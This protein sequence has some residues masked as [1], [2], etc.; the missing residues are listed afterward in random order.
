MNELASKEDLKGEQKQEPVARKGKPWAALLAVVALLLAIVALIVSSLFWQH[1]KQA[2]AQLLQLNQSINHGSQVQSGNVK[3]LSATQQTLQT[4][5]KLIQANQATLTRLL[6]SISTDKSNWLVTDAVHLIKLA[7][8]TL[9]FQYDIPTT[10]TLLKTANQRLSASGD[11]KL[12]PVRKLLVNDIIKLQTTPKVDVSTLYL[13]LQALRKATMALPLTSDHY[14]N[15]KSSNLL[16]KQSDKSGSWWQH[17]VN[18]TSNALSKVLVVRERKMPVMP[19][20]TPKQHRLL[21]QSI[22]VLYSQAQWAIMQRQQTVYQGALAQLE[23]LIATYFSAD[24]QSQA[25]LKHL[26]QLAK[27][28]VAP[29]LPNVSDSLEALQNYVKAKQRKQLLGSMP[30]GKTKAAQP[31]TTQGAK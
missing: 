25:I 6:Q 17:A 19:L 23:K 15:D 11:P 16:A 1:L 12:Y 14:Q 2:D 22:Y 4:Q 26:S 20:I 24:T 28:N 30:Q 13:K 3:Q 18:S 10:I 27:T 29:T 8:M 21:L 9:Y 5:A 31:T 7:N